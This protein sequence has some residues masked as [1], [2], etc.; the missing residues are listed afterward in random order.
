MFPKNSPY[1]ELEDLKL[2][3]YSSYIRFSI[4]R[5]SSWHRK[6]DLEPE[7]QVLEEL[8]D[9]GCA[10]GAAAAAPARD[11]ERG[12]LSLGVGDA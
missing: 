12:A 8:E 7:K 10:A 6:N 11:E 5:I 9:C 1:H 3:S 4:P 2:L